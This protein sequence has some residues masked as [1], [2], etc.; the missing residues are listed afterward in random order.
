MFTHSL[1]CHSAL[2][3][4][5]LRIFFSPSRPS[6]GPT[7]RTSENAE[8]ASALAAAAVAAAAPADHDGAE[9]PG[10]KEF[11]ERRK[12]RKGAEALRYAH[13]LKKRLSLAS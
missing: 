2:N 4:E 13:L 3:H 7:S 6:R 8:A 10:S 11:Q 12:K 1:A 9:E 5:P